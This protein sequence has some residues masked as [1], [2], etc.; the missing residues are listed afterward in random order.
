MSRAHKLVAD[1][2]GGDIAPEDQ[3]DII[4]ALEELRDRKKWGPYHVNPIMIHVGFRAHLGSFS[5]LVEQF[6]SIPLPEENIEMAIEWSLEIYTWET[7]WDVA[8]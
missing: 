3:G 8:P 4:Q 7:T 1:L 5:M 2:P 6:K